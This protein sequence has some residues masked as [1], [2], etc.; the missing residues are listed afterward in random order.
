MQVETNIETST[1]SRP[2]QDFIRLAIAFFSCLVLLSFYHHI[3][4][5][6]GGVIDSVVNKS[7]FLLVVHHIG[8]TAMTALLLVFLFTFLERKKENL[9]FKTAKFIFICIFV[10]EALLV[11]FYIQHY[12]IL[13]LEIFSRLYEDFGVLQLGLY[14]LVFATMAVVL[15]PVIYRYTA[16]SYRLINRM[17][18]LTFILFTFFL[19]TLITAK[20]PVNENKLQHLVV[21][22]VNQVMDESPYEGEIEYPLAKAAVRDTT[23]VNHFKAASSRPDII[24]LLVEGLSRDFV[25]SDAPYRSFMPFLNKLRIRS[26]FWNNALSNGAESHHALPSVLG[27]LPFG[28]SGFTETDPSP[29][30]NTLLSILKDNGY[31]TRFY[32]G[33][34]SALHR[35]DK[36]LFEEKTDRI[37]DIK[38]F[39]KSFTK[40]DEDRAGISWGYPDSE[41][42]RKYSEDLLPRDRPSL[43]VLQTLST[44]R[45]Y[46]IPEAERYKELVKRMVNS[47]DLSPRSVKIV[48]NNRDL[49]AGFIYADQA[50]ANLFEDLESRPQYQNT[51][52][53]ITGTH[54]AE[55]LPHQDNLERY[56]V[57]LML[58]SPLLNK[59]AEFSQLVSHADIAPSLI[60]LVDHYT[61]LRLPSQTA[62]LGKGLGESTDKAIP[63]IRYRKGIKD[64]VLGNTFVT[65]NRHYQIKESGELI[66][67]EDP[68]IISRLDEGLDK[69]KKIN[70]YVTSQNKILPDEY[71]MVKMKEGL[72]NEEM[73]WVNS[74]FSGSDYDRAYNT[75]R[76]LAFNGER[77]RALLLCEYIMMNVPGHVDTEI[78]MGRIHA[79]NRQFSLAERILK[80]CIRKY[81]LYTDS[82]AALLDVYYWAGT[83]Q[84]A[85]GIERKLKSRN[86][87]DQALKEKIERAK[88]Q[89][90]NAKR[91]EILSNVRPAISDIH[92]EDL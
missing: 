21:G 12:E 84:K 34:N 89:I 68:A 90:R 88:K 15:F 46:K 73:I 60:G 48:K 43:E 86:I 66:E 76:K 80:E 31:Q 52:V 61:P 16:R 69:F 59:S 63:L 58:V 5:Y 62:W 17:Y 28:E 19:A 77:D 40:Q 65:G 25:G 35:V 56:R 74:V 71:A 44:K 41:L 39:D 83:N 92:F 11:E 38:S 70:K 42:F 32:Y 47:G 27:S 55:G 20:K 8:F 14:S 50:I 36:F 26:L 2:L 64:F 30:R 67:L 81:P 87:E 85:L 82:Y 18:P 37:T 51:I 24:I 49:M 7:F 53:L 72:T 75:A 13:S 79:W 29:G 57:P 1:V 10:C 22:A 4:L 33:G 45:P 6:A 91:K 9:G 54:R 23:L 3:R 78:L